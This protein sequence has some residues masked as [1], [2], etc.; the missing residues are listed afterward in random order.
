MAVM[1]P[2]MPNAIPWSLPRKALPKMASE[3]A[4]MIAPPTPCTA[5]D[6]SSM[7]GVWAAPQSAE[8]AVKITSPI[9]HRRLRPYRSANDP[10][11]SSR[12]ARVRA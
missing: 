7:R 1:A 4:N 3:S 2:Q 9:I 10:P 12:A 8:A 11:V 6:S 5:R